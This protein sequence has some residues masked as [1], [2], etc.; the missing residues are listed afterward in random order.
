MSSSVISYILYNNVS[1]T[2]LKLNYEECST[3]TYSMICSAV[4]IFTYSPY[5][6]THQPNS[7]TYEEN[8]ELNS[9]LL[10]PK[11]KCSTRGSYHTC[12]QARLNFQRWTQQVY[13]ADHSPRWNKQQPPEAFCQGAVENLFHPTPFHISSL[14]F[15]GLPPP[16]TLHSQ[17]VNLLFLANMENLSTDEKDIR[18]TLSSYEILSLCSYI[19]FKLSRKYRCNQFAHN[20]TLELRKET[21]AAPQNMYPTIAEAE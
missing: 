4:D 18:N 5:L 14:V 2:S 8:L 1:K 15:L 12:F 21:R 9:Y 17:S 6:L 13:M 11:E 7:Q 20:S 16:A 3:T 19:I 10:F